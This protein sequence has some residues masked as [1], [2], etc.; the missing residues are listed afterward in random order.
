MGLS[1]QE[2]ERFNSDG[3]LGPFRLFGRDVALQIGQRIRTQILTRRCEVYAHTKGDF[4]KLDY[5]RD[6][7]LDSPL[8]YRCA[9]APAIVSRIASLLGPDILLWRSDLFL[10]RLKDPGTH[11][12]QDIDLSGTRVIPS[13]EAGTEHAPIG[14]IDYPDR[15]VMLPLCVSAWI[16]FD[17]ITAQ[18]GALYYVA[19]THKSV[20]PE[21]PGSGVAGRPLVLS[22][23]FERSEH[24]V[25]EIDAGELMLF[26]N[27][28]VHGSYE[29]ESGER[30]AWTT[31]YVQPDTR[32]YPNGPINAQG[33]DLANF[34]SV[35]VAG[36]DRARVNILRAPPMI[37][38]GPILDE[39]A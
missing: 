10:Q 32:I 35:L 26:H 22:R 29:V 5:M 27:L 39:R 14:K 2:I 33:Q 6:R 13:I 3:F 25:V 30:L 1:R 38:E 12:H 34:G 36:R 4:E 37:G 7:H 18:N 15:T 31:R 19:G 9:T 17:K 20:I 11:P 24:H 23:T 28:M 21:V 16:A 8:L